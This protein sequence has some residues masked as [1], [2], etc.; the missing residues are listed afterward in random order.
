[1][2]RASPVMVGGKVSSSEMTVKQAEWCQLWSA[3]ERSGLSDL[4]R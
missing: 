1:M 2:R 4:L 3:H